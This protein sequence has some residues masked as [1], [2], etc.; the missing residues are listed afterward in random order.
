LAVQETLKLKLTQLIEETLEL[1]YSIQVPS[2]DADF[3]EVHKILIQ[4]QSILSEIE[5][6]LSSAIRA[7]SASDRKIFVTKMA[8]QEKWDR[9]IVKVNSRP[10]L[11]EY[12]TGKEK[13]AEA[14]LD[15][16]NE[17]RA[18]R[19]EEELQSFASEAVDVIR[20]HYYGLDKV[21]Q[22]LRKRL[23]LESNAAYS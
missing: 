17:S 11:S 5:R 3:I 8:Y 14:N 1:R 19:K 23:D 22:D 15:T 6:K 12:A 2:Y 13:A 16:L 7:K 21:R 10:N 18:L 9:A 4:S 20:L